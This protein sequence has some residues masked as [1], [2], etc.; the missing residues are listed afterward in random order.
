[1]L[2]K[3]ISHVKF[4]ILNPTKRQN[5]YKRYSGTHLCCVTQHKVGTGQ[6][7]HGSRHRYSQ[8]RCR[9]CLKTVCR[10]QETNN[11]PQYCVYMYSE[12]T[13]PP[14]NTVFVPALLCV[15]ACGSSTFLLVCDVLLRQLRHLTLLHHHHLN[16]CLIGHTYTGFILV[17][18]APKNQ[19]YLNKSRRTIIYIHIKHTKRHALSTDHITTMKRI[20]FSPVNE[21]KWFLLS[22]PTYLSHSLLFRARLIQI[23]SFMGVEFWSLCK[24]V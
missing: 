10:Q 13:Q 23:H 2:W 12:H 9:P 16:L 22:L 15:H 17:L 3:C 18:A 4:R 8:G 21:L 6:T 19:C 14:A 11:S 7:G 1:M 24:L 20:I 5:V